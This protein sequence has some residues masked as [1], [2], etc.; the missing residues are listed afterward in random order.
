MENKQIQLLETYEKLLVSWDKTHN[1]IYFSQRKNLKQHIEDSLSVSLMVSDFV[2]DLGSGGGLPGIPLAIAN[3]NKQFLL[4]E[5][6]T[7]KASFLLNTVTKL[8]L[9]NTE[10]INNR[11]ENIDHSNFPDCFDI[12]SRAVGSTEA[13]IALTAELLNKKGVHLKLMKTEEQFCKEKLP[14]GFS[15][16][17]IDKFPSKTK[18][19]TRILVTIEKVRQ[20]G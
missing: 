16:K 9:K 14:T 1:L 12:V 7:K 10:V 11:I 17:K 5:S 19:K 8:D 2:V 3:P 15:V 6:N 18:D 4:V 20:N 13:N